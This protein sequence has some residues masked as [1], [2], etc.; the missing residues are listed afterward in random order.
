[1][2]ENRVIG[3]DN[4]LPWHLPADMKHFKTLTMGHAVVMGRKTWLT[5]GKPLKNRLNIVLSRT[6]DIG[7]QPH[8]LKHMLGK[9]E[10][11]E[12]ARGFGRDIY[13][14]G[15]RRVFESFADVI[16]KWIVTEVPLEVEDAD[17]FMPA[18][19][20]DGFELTGT[21]DLDDGLKVKFLTR[22]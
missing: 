13:I 10:V 1:M 20:L 16:E 18:N 17:T 8:V 19:F 5:I 3:R 9:E 7:D 4:A 22:S 11:L 12:F 14:I 6:A 2:A 21:Q 15:G